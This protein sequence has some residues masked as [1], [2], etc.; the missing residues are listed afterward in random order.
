MVWHVVVSTC[1]FTGGLC[2]CAHEVRLGAHEVRLG[3]KEQGQEVKLGMK[4]M[5]SD[6]GSGTD[7]LA[8]G[9]KKLGEE[10]GHMSTLLWGKKKNWLWGNEKN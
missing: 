10:V 7:H 9:L 2:Y 6:A 3:L 8:S 4:G 5:M 1:I